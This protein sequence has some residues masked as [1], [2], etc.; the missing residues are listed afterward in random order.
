M[1]GGCEIG[2]GQSKQGGNGKEKGRRYGVN[3]SAISRMSVTR[4]RIPVVTVRR[5]ISERRIIRE[6]MMTR[7]MKE[8]GNEEQRLN[9]LF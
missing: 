6:K 7:N 5:M 3:D 4:R 8:V 9:K 1:V 2:G